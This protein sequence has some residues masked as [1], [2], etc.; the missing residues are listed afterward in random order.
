MLSIYCN[1]THR[2]NI[3]VSLGVF[4][5]QSSRLPG[6]QGR[7]ADVSEVR[8]KVQA[9]SMF[10]KIHEH[11]EQNPERK[12]TIFIYIHHYSSIFIYIQNV[13]KPAGSWSHIKSGLSSGASTPRGVLCTKGA[14]PAGAHR[15]HG[16]P[17]DPSRQTTVARC[18]DVEDVQRWLVRC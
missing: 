1:W 13:C 9:T 2:W 7:S 3:F 18:R 17:E 8:K 5:F 16:P 6:D 10:P 4:K 14:G 11:L 15:H 12:Q